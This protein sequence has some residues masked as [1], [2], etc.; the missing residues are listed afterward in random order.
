MN[1]RS[2]V[3][4]LV[5][6]LAVVSAVGI[7]P[8]PAAAAVAGPDEP[9][10][11][12]RPRYT[13]GQ[14]NRFQ[15]VMHSR[16]QTQFLDTPRVR[17]QEYEQRMRVRRKVLEVGPSGAT[18]EV[19]YEAVVV[20][21]VAG[22]KTITYDSEGINGA[23]P[24]E[25]LG[26]TTRNAINRPFTVKVDADGNVLSVSGNEQDGTKMAAASLIDSEILTRSLG[27]IYGLGK[28][29][30]PIAIGQEWTES[31]ASKPDLSGVFTTTIKS[32]L[33][34]VTGARATIDLS[35]GLALEP[36]Q[37]AVEGHAQL[38][39]QSVAGVRVWN[40][41][42]GVIDRAVYQQTMKIEADV[43]SIQAT[44][45]HGTVRRREGRTLL[46]VAIDRI[47]DGVAP[48][49]PLPPIPEATAAVVRP[50]AAT[51]GKSDP[52]PNVIL[53]PPEEEKPAPAGGH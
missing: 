8:V 36:S 19:T 33:A 3:G 37:K 32:T 52:I 28:V 13:V 23:E 39:G 1:R 6:V 9:R 11:N 24:E 30:E 51:D 20:T 15:V 42:E 21:L 35:G 34:S 48:L 22:N 49:P 47:D 45:E 25:V 31:R 46:Y 40:I 4:L 7:R 16:T 10:I 14:E 38:T 43:E 29:P 17:L 41:F 50:A 26:P 27:P 12:L 53:T 44:Q 18:I 5:M 2:C